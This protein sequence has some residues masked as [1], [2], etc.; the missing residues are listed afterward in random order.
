M[1]YVKLSKEMSYALRHAP[2]EYELELDE[3]GFASIDQLLAAINE[4]GDYGCEVTISDLREVIN[5]SDKKRHEVVDD[6]IR[7][8]YGHTVPKRIEKKAAE[9]PATLYHG[10]S[11]QAAE[12][13]L[14]EGLKPMSRQ[15]VH[16]S[17]DVETAQKVGERRDF[18]PV[19]LVIDSNAA[20]GDGIPFYIG[21][22]KVWLA[23]EVPARFIEIFSPQNGSRGD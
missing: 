7:A 9:P 23:D 13:I 3:E 2:W 19:I 14:A 15:Y 21:N 10:T 11:R 16:L 17:L 18:N 6:R 20:F 5:R 4:G 22:D 1:D 8:L 12:I